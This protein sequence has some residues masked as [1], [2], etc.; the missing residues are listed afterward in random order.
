[1]TVHEKESIQLD[2]F[3]NKQTIAS[4]THLLDKI[5]YVS[6][7]KSLGIP[8]R[9]IMMNERMASTRFPTA[10]IA[11]PFTD[12]AS[13]MTLPPKLLLDLKPEHGVIQPGRY[14]RFLLGIESSL[15][16]LGI[17]C[18]IPHRDINKW[19]NKKLSPEKG[20]ELCTKYVHSSDIFVG[21]IGTS[22]GSHYELGLA[23]GEKKPII[24][25]KCDEFPQ[26]FIGKGIVENIEYLKVLSANSMNDV[27][28][29]LLSQ[30]VQ[31]FLSRHIPVI[32]RE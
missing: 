32:W 11:A 8:V 6:T 2:M 25:I 14:R 21:I 29:L 17:N 15:N 3:V 9:P 12:F 26:S 28:H 22:N 19:G 20:T 7:E 31:V 23:M 4:N 16:K 24:L 18:F 1:M 30:D 10:Y 5:Y 27:K 13:E